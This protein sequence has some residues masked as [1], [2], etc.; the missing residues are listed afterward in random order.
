[1]PP[2]ASQ[3]AV[4]A[5]A[6][7]KTYGSTRALDGVDLEI[8]SGTVLGLLG[9]NGA[10]KTTTVR[11]LTTLLKPDSGRAFV[12]GH[13]VLADPAAVRRSIGLSGQYAAVDENLT[14][15]ENLYMV[16]RLY[17]MSRS[18]SG[19]R[20][21]AL[22]DRFRLKDAAERPA[23]TYSGG[24]RRRLDLAGALVAEPTV[25]VLDE[26]TT[27]LDPRGRMDTWDVIGELVADGAT[28]LLTTQYLEEADQLADNILV[29]DRGKVIAGGT[30]DQLKNGVGGERIEVVVG[31]ASE[32][33]KTRQIL[34]SLGSSEPS[35]DEHQ[36]RVSVKVDT[37]PKALVEAL[38]RLDQEGIAVLDVALHRPT[39]DDVFLS[40]TGHAAE[41]VA[42]PSEPQSKGRK[43]KKGA[44]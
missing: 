19:A 23:K 28:V 25:V 30:P 22:L 41:E 24:M 12:A 7:V 26:P 40:L 42:E 4:H 21:R 44:S 36:R 35:V 8:R 29:I 3:V 32:V 2:S 6:L 34:F 5:E 14:G 11:I 39:L 43:S 15:Y 27:G 18:D 9:P 38:R 1:M 37:G 20:A 10:G 13:D 31:E 17:G 33:E 16:G